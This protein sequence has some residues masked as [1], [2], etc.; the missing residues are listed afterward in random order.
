MQV[1]FNYY[2]SQNNIQYEVS[3]LFSDTLAFL[4]QKQ[5]QFMMDVETRLKRIEGKV[6]DLESNQKKLEL[7]VNPENKDAS[8]TLSHMPPPMPA[9]TGTGTKRPLEESIDVSKTAPNITTPI[10]SVTAPGVKRP[11]E[12]N[13]L[14]QTV[15]KFAPETSDEQFLA[16][17][18]PVLRSDELDKKFRAETIPNDQTHI[19]RDQNVNIYDET[20]KLLIV[21]RTNV[22]LQKYAT[23]LRKTYYFCSQKYNNS[24]SRGD[25]AG[26][27]DAT[28]HG[29]KSEDFVVNKFGIKAKRVGGN[30]SVGNRHQSVTFGYLAHSV[31]GKCREAVRKIN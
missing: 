3:K 19:L 21:F 23:L 20:G 22:N 25:A 9:V 4:F 2:N 28:T 30:Y 7:L 16:L 31:K 8:E 29:K 6:T 1:N 18:I 11:L 10:P 15:K 5:T 26:K 14:I 17:K 12:E 27:F 24:T 13:T